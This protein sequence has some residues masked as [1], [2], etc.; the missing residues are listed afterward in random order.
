MPVIN[1][2]VQ[3]YQQTLSCKH[4]LTAVLSYTL[5]GAVSQTF[6]RNTIKQKPTGPSERSKKLIVMDVAFKTLVRELHLY[7]TRIV[8]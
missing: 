1:L 5:H 6:Q 2:L 8:N 7:Y 3:P 4:Y